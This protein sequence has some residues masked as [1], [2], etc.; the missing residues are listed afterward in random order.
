VLTSDSERQIFTIVNKDQ[1]IDLHFADMFAVLKYLSIQ[2]NRID[3]EFLSKKDRQYVSSIEKE[4]LQ[5]IKDQ[6]KTNKINEL[7]NT[8]SN[9]EIKG[10]SINNNKAIHAKYHVR[11]NRPRVCMGCD[12][13]SEANV[14]IMSGSK[15][16]LW[17]TGSVGYKNIWNKKHYYEAALNFYDYAVDRV[18]E[19]KLQSGG[20]ISSKNILDYAG[21]IATYFNIQ[22]NQ[23]FQDCLVFTMKKKLTLVLGDDQIKPWDK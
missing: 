2:D 15:V 16:L 5:I 3:L 14:I 7:K 23:A 11:F 17:E 8:I 6:E 4:K 20:R 10:I 21:E 13:G 19:K 9:I 1:N 12:Y 22:N 18:S